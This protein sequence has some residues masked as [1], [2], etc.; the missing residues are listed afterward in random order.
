MQ[1][2][3]INV[4]D[5]ARRTVCGVAG[6]GTLPAQL[7]K[8]LPAFLCVGLITTAPLSSPSAWWHALAPH[9]VPRPPL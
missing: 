2:A 1:L 4:R 6:T 5:Y 8:F 3:H 9:P 7:N